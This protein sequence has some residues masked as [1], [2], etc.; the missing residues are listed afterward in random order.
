[1]G[2]VQFYDGVVLFGDSDGNNTDKVAMHEDCCCIGEPCEHCSGDAPLQLQVDF[3]NV[4]DNNCLT[5]D[6]YYAQSFILDQTGANP[7]IWEFIE[8]DWCAG[9]GSGEE[10]STH[11]TA[12]YIKV[13]SD[14]RL[15]VYV[16]E[17]DCCSGAA[18]EIMVAYFEKDYGASEPACEPGTP[19]TV[20]PQDTGLW[21][22]QACTW[23]HT[24][25][26]CQV[27]AV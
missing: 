10:T 16:Y 21:S 9:C 6:T 12:E 19:V 8:E 22:D 18:V 20:L 3:T 25:V 24:V 27:S 15:R 4:A 14:Y 17:C 1:M 26:T 2:T 23:D 11:I 7:C 13:G 5:C